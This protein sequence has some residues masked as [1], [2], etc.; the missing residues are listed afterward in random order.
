MC[1]PSRP[2]TAAYMVPLLLLLVL[3][4][5]ALVPLAL[6]AALLYTTLQVRGARRAVL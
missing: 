6:V 5:P 1:H 2:S 3:A 4:V